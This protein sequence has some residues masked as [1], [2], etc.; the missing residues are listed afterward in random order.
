MQEDKVAFLESLFG[1]GKRSGN[2]ILFFCPFCHHHKKKLSINLESDR[3]RCWVC[4]KNGKRLFYVLKEVGGREDLETYSRFYKSKQVVDFRVPDYKD[5]DFFLRL[6]DE[7]VPIVNCRNSILGRRAFNYLTETR[8]ISE[9]DILRYKLGVLIS[10]EHKGRIVIP[11]F[12]SRGLVNW[13]TTRDVIDKGYWNP[14]VP[15]GYKNQIIPNDL[16]V[17][18]SEPVVL[19]EGPIDWLKSIKNTIPLLGTFLSKYSALFQKIVKS[20]IPVF[21]A[22]DLDAV[23]KSHR[24]AENLLAAG[25]PVYNVSVYPYEDVGAMPKEEFMRR[26]EAAEI[27]DKTGIFRKKLRALC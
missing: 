21:L 12:D 24:I 27:L 4:E 11:F 14:E 3:W 1:Q 2:E 18:W 8:G 16:N 13:Y 26:Y 9:E 5:L 15:H 20:E 23:E 6:P 22:L 17:D 7:F 25:V 19:V 10:G